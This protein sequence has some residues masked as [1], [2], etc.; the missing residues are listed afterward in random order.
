M[1]Y[2]KGRWKQKPNRCSKPVEFVYN[3]ILSWAMEIGGLRWDAFPHVG[4][5]DRAVGDG[6][7]NGNLKSIAS[8][9][10]WEIESTEY[11]LT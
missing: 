5:D 6:W 4:R 3:S 9:N 2:S 7:M 1:L 8:E 11:V 10:P